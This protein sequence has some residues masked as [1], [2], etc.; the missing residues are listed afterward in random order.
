[1]ASM[2]TTAE[3]NLDKFGEIL[4]MVFADVSDDKMDKLLSD[5]KPGGGTGCIEAQS[6][7]EWAKEE[8]KRRKRINHG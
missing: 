1:M 8:I 3:A 4:N 5:I 2:S 6:D 7:A